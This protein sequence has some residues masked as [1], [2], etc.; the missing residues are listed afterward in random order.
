MDSAG[1]I[2]CLVMLEVLRVLEKEYPFLPRDCLS[3]RARSLTRLQTKTY[4]MRQRE[5]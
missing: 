1:R 4:S 2:S 5:A 3:A